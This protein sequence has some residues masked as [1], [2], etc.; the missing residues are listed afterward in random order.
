MRIKHGIFVVMLMTSANLFAQ[1]EEK[2]KNQRVVPATITRDGN[3][4]E[5]YM[6]KM[7]TDEIPF[8]TSGTKFSAPWTFQKEVLFMEKSRFESMPKIKYK[9][10]ERLGPG[11]IQ[12]Y[13]YNN[14]SLSFES[15]KYANLNNPGLG[16]MPKLVFLRKLAKHSKIS[17]YVHYTAPSGNGPED[18]QTA[19]FKDAAIPYLVYFK[20]GDDNAKGVGVLNIEKQLSDC[21]KVV[22]HYKK[23]DY[24]KQGTEREEYGDYLANASD[25]DISKL[26]AIAEYNRGHCD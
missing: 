8:T 5:G 11:D 25:Q 12:G 26:Y 19:E 1:L 20:A 15:R 10:Y 9:D 4:I 13:S 16:M 2:I 6:I 17:V 14:D 24:K 3:K 7:G 18:K 22:E 23:G 21:P